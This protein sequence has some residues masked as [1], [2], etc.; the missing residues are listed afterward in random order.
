MLKYLKLFENFETNNL[1]N[2]T[3]EDVIGSVKDYIYKTYTADQ[4]ELDNPYGCD[5]KDL[6]EED[7]AL[8]DEYDID[9][10]DPDYWKSDRFIE[11]MG[12]ENCGISLPY[13]FGYIKEDLMKL[14]QNITI[15]R[16]ISVDHNFTTNFKNGEIDSLG[17]YWSYSKFDLA[18]QMHKKLDYLVVFECKVDTKNVN[19]QQTILYNLNYAVGGNEREIILNRDA[20]LTLINAFVTN[21]TVEERFFPFY[22]KSLYSIIDISNLRDK[23]F[24]I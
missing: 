2:I 1:S 12:D 8:C 11:M 10:N 16:C 5:S 19:W 17:K 3:L 4:N 21:K 20:K 14:G 18:T 9:C 23:Y 24:T 15:W 22:D 13:R 6:L 7:V